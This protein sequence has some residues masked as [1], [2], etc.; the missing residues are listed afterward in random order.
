VIVVLVRLSEK[1]IY[2]KRVPVKGSPA[3]PETRRLYISKS[4]DRAT[5]AL[6]RSYANI[7]DE[8]E[9]AGYS[10]AEIARIKGELQHYL[11]VREIIRKASGMSS[12]A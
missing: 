5:A 1:S 12:F 6:V 9:A 7:A 8:L 4:T 10:E 11:D 3:D 2:W